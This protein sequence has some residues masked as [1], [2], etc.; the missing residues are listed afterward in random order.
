ML[1]Y[2][3]EGGGERKRAHQWAN[4]ADT[5]VR[6]T[7]YMLYRS[8]NHIDINSSG[9]LRQDNWNIRPQTNVL[10]CIILFSCKK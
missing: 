4:A 2:E 10:T 6:N 9:Y 1:V 5:H 3:R 8:L 7:L